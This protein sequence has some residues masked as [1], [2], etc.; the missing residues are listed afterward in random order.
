MLPTNI[1]IMC[2]GFTLF[3]PCNP[4][5]VLRLSSPLSF[6]TLPRRVNLG[7]IIKF[8]IR[9]PVILLNGRGVACAFQELNL[10]GLK[11]LSS[12]VMSRLFGRRV[13]R[14]R[15]FGPKPRFSTSTYVLRCPYYSTSAPLSYSSTTDGI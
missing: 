3:R 6:V 2:S 14:R 4:N 13:P 1:S 5:S 9:P 7:H 10:F 8:Y 15:G 11:L 12:M